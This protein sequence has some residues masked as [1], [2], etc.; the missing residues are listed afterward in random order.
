MDEHE[1]RRL[2]AG[3]RV[4]YGGDPDDLGTVAAAFPLGVTVR[5]DRDR[6][7]TPLRHEDC[8]AIERV[9]VA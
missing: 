4:F 9:V 5:W 7:P 3:V 8:D 1:A 2:S 6:L